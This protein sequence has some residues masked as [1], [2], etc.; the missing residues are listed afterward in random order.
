MITSSDS[1]NTYDLGKYYAILP[2][3]QNWN[4]DEFISKFNAIKVE[5]GF[6]YSS[7]NN[8]DWLSVDNLKI[9]V[10]NYI[11]NTSK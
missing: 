9:I 2:T 6:S 1:F 3:T 4:L 10:L 7:G 5:E 8:R 11:N